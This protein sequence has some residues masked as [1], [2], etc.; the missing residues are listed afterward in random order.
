MRS[1]SRD[2][3]GRVAA[4]LIPSV[5]MVVVLA[6][7]ALAGWTASMTKSQTVTMATLAAPTGLTAANGVCVARTSSPVDLAWTAT[8]SNFADG[9]EVFR[10]TTTGGPYTSLGTVNGPNTTTF[11][12]TTA[13]F[14]KSY[15]YVVQAK[16]NLWRSP[17]SNEATATT[18]RPNCG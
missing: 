1:R 6:A 17:S 16:R 11:V 5:V 2:P 13:A 15:F 3:L 4:T 14:N 8:S 10:S 7:P 9:Y 18:P 12:D